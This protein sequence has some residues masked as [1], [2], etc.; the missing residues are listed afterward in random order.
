LG[1]ILES[2]AY[3]LPLHSCQRS[4]EPESEKI[5]YGGAGTCSPEKNDFEIV[6]GVFWCVFYNSFSQ[7]FYQIFIR[8]A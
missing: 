2:T 7:L 3:F 6:F 1:W 8:L 4:D 5:F